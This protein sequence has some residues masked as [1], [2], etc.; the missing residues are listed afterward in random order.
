MKLLLASACNWAFP[1]P[2]LW[3]FTMESRAREGLPSMLHK[4]FSYHHRYKTGVWGHWSA[5]KVELQRIRG[6]TLSFLSTPVSIPQLIYRSCTIS[7]YLSMSKEVAKLQQL[8]LTLSVWPEHWVL[9]YRISLNRGWSLYTNGQR[10]YHSLCF[11]YICGLVKWLQ[12]QKAWHKPSLT[13]TG[14]GGMLYLYSRVLPWGVSSLT[15]V[16]C[17]QSALSNKYLGSKQAGVGWTEPWVKSS[18]T[19]ADLG[20]TPEFLGES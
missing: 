1:K 7:H 5:E 16:P 13:N 18:C 11:H 12:F 15:A 3:T 2:S 14:A 4:I 10:T 6:M 8:S 17:W 9:S 20:S 19:R